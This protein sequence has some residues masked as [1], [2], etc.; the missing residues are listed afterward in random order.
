MP[1]K[2]L[3]KNIAN[4]WSTGDVIAVMEHTA[5]LGRLELKSKFIEMGGTHETWPRHFVVVNITDVDKSYYEYLLEENSQDLRRYFITP[6]GHE[7]PYYDELL[8]NAEI[9]TTSAVIDSLVQDRGE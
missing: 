7:S 2:L 6:Q 8:Q 9:T 1:C 5:P 4:A 3:V